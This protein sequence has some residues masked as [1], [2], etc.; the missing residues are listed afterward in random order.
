MIKEKLYLPLLGFISTSAA[1][2]LVTLRGISQTN[3]GDAFDYLNAGLAIANGDPYPRTASLPFFRPPGYPALIALLS[4]I[5]EEQIVALLKIANITLHV[6]TTF[7]IY[8]ICQKKFNSKSALFAAGFYSINPLS[9]HQV[10]GVSTETLTAFLFLTFAYL[11]SFPL[12]VSK[13]FLLGAV[14]LFLTSVRPEYFFVV[15]PIYLWIY[16]RRRASKKNLVSSS[17]VLALIFTSI[18]LWGASNQQAT[19]KFIPFTDAANYH[20][21]MGSLDLIASNYPL[22]F[23]NGRDFDQIQWNLLVSEIETQKQSWGAKYEA[24]PIGEKSEFWS[25]AFL[26]SVEDQGFISY[27]QLLLFKGVIFWRPFLNPSSYDL[28]SV[29][30]SLPLLTSMTL[31]FVFGLRYFFRR[32]NIRTLVQIYSF[33]LLVITAVHMLQLPD[34]RYRIPLFL[35]I[36]AIMF[37]GLISTRLK[38]EKFL[39][40]I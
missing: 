14:M 30:L 25:K 11:L 21:W 16:V 4:I 17:I 35:P 2:L 18:G 28:A 13:N 31:L 9:L 29:L 40:R 19:G 3:F 10:T 37:G 7:L 27:L 24:S 38:C 15:M 12:S 33:G 20:L 1:T 5:S 6:G 36:C 32:E 26:A 34:L 22:T 23:G 39:T 8:F